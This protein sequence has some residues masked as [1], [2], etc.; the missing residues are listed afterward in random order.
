M[1]IVSY[2]PAII[3]TSRMDV[4]GLNSALLTYLE[5]SNIDGL[6]K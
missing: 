3:T 4:V 2:I 5:S 1:E 6:L